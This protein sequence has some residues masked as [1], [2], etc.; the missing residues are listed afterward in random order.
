MNMPILPLILLFSISSGLKTGG[1][2]G[3]DPSL[4]SCETPPAIPATISYDGVFQPF[5]SAAPPINFIDPIA[6]PAIPSPDDFER[7]DQDGMPVLMGPEPYTV[8]PADAFGALGG[9]GSFV[10]TTPPPFSTIAVTWTKQATFNASLALFGYTPDLAGLDSVRV[11]G[12]FVRELRR[13]L[14]A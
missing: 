9:Y 6:L 2:E 8:V 12:P 7:Y 14:T 13:R 5:S 4:A 1:R 3:C 10:T 11:D